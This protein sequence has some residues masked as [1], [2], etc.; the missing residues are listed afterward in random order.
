MKRNWIRVTVVVLAGCLLYGCG[1]IEMK[2]NAPENSIGVVLKAI[3][4]PYWLDVETGMEQAAVELG[5]DLNLVYPSG[6]QEVREQ[7]DLVDDMLNSDVDLLMVAP[8]DCYD[9]NWIADKAEDQGIVLLT[10]DDR[11]MDVNIPFIGSD[12]KLIGKLTAEY[13]NQTLP[14]G[15]SIYVLLGPENQMSNIDRLWGIENGLDPSFHIQ[16][17]TYTELT[18]DNGYQAVKQA[19]EKIDGLFC[20][21]VVASSG[22]VA[23]L[24]EKGWN[25]Q[26]IT[27]DTGEDAYQVLKS[28]MID[29]FLRQDG[30]EIGYNAIKIAAETLDSGELPEDTFFESELIT[31]DTQEER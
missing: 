8:C 12:N 4:S 23:A 16:Q 5:I 9:T 1:T 13:F 14:E 24:E 20:Q 2:R 21:N 19:E 31:M 11:A 7:K 10:V 15:S 29:A 26:V 18:E 22:A 3:N 27:V 25:A 17:V 28:G 6:E 30:Y